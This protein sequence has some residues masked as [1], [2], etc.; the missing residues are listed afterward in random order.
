MS[1]LSKRSPKWQDFILD[2]ANLANEFPGH[3]GDNGSCSIMFYGEKA[4]DGI[5]AGSFIDVTDVTVLCNA[6]YRVLE[7]VP[8]FI[9]AY[10][11][12][13][14]MA[15]PLLE[16]EDLKQCVDTSI[17]VLLKLRAKLEKKD[18]KSEEI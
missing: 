1:D 10:L 15:L 6:F 16:K 5:A 12:A 4:E 17:T 11:A 9:P 13:T 8:D 7:E 14:L 2:M 18:V 3:K